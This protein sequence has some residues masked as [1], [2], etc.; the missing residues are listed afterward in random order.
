M[1]Q[2]AVREPARFRRPRGRLR[3]GLV[4]LLCLLAGLGLGLGLPRISIG[5]SVAS[6][7]VTEALTAIGF[8]TLGLVT[9][10][11]SL[12]FL[13]VQ[14][15]FGSLSPRLNLFRDDPIVW[16]TFGVAIGVF[17]FSVTAALAIANDPQVSVIVPAAEVAAVLLA[18]ALVRVLLVRAFTSIQLAPTLA[19]IAAKGRAILDDLYRRPCPPGPRAATVLPPLHRAVAWPYGQA[20]LQQVNLPRLLQAAGRAVIVFRAGIGD[21]LQ[22]GAPVADLHGGEVA[23]EAV[24]DAL[25][26]GQERTF[27][28]DPLF[29]FR[30]L[31]DIGLRALSPAVNDP[32]TAVQVLDTIQGIL[33]PLVDRDLDVADIAD[34]SGAVRV[35]L[36]FPSWDDY[37][38]TS[39]DDLI[40]SAARSPMV[41]LR[42]RTLL[43]TLLNTAPPQRR[44]SISRRLNRAQ[45]LLTVNFPAIWQDA[46]GQ[47]GLPE[48][49]LARA[50]EQ[51]VADR[52]GDLAEANCLQPGEEGGG[53]DRVVGV[54]LVVPV[55][56][57]AGEAVGADERPAGAQRAQC[58]GQDRVLQGAGRDVVQHGE[59]ADGVEG[60]G[61][62]GQ[63]G[64]VPGDGLDVRARKPRPERGGG[65][66]FEFEGDKPL[67]PLPQP[68]R[69]RAGTR[70]DLE[71]VVT[72]VNAVRDH[73][74]DLFVQERG[75]L[76]RP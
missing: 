4:Q 2:P 72:E 62:V 61:G 22:Q 20:T 30:L 40:E 52:Q 51:A 7:R 54:A 31:A 9:V 8:G 68:L 26:T 70:A 69:R 42:A 65:L 21:T 67:D 57:V 58:P 63:R 41:L 39:L 11:F 29:A 66:W 16:R 71:Q 46:N 12:L 43:S 33:S 75:P 50:E 44:P 24:L 34:G 74:Q 47:D 55:Q 60:L 28:Q 35:I 36:A 1:R 48:R 38:R 27:N 19:V 49:R 76:G 5:P 18:V 56:T 32:A 13:V 3:A 15:A 6:T 45:D 64:R 73:G 53:L 17:V 23:D 25:L 10:I 37:L 14:W 59:H